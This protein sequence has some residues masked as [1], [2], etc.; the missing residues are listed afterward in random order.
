MQKSQLMG[1]IYK[2]GRL[3]LKIYT[4]NMGSEFYLD[5]FDENA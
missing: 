5:I 4:N 2:E 3:S 1:G